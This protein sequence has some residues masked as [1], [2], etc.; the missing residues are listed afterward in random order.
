MI[1]ERAKIVEKHAVLHLSLLGPFLINI[2]SFES[3]RFSTS[4]LFKKLEQ[5]HQQ[6]LFTLNETWPCSTVPLFRFKY[7]PCYSTGE[8]VCVRV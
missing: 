5:Q 4:T 1:N 7:P 6:V 2:G 3:L 8:R